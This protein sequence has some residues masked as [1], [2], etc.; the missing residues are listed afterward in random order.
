MNIFNYKQFSSFIASTIY[1]INERKTIENA[2]TNGVTIWNFMSDTD[3]D[4]VIQSKTDMQKTTNNLVK[5][6]L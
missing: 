5:E 3:S 1:N 6:V 4:A 2:L